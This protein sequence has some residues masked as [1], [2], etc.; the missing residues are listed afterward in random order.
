MRKFI[1]M[2]VAVVFAFVACDSQPTAVSDELINAPQFSATGGFDEFGYNYR[3]RVFVGAA[4]G[5]DRNLDGMVWGDPTYANDHL[6]MKWSKGWDDARFHGGDWTPDAWEDNQWNG[7]KPGGSG[8]TWHYKIQWVGPCGSD[9]DPL[10]D[11]GYCIWGQFEV[12][13]SHGT[14][15]AEHFWETHANPA[16]Y[17]S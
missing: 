10:P 8:E 4:D 17:G 16:G 12:I 3:A 6:K 5:V 15:D 9:G 1:A 2:S 7:M 13:M 11:G 14:F